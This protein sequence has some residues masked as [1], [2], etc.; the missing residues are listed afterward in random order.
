MSFLVANATHAPPV[1]VKGTVARPSCHPIGPISSDCTLL[2]DQ[3]S[4]P[5]ATFKSSWPSLCS[6][7]T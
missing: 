6:E 1:W 4:I 2:I 7:G 3:L 5:I